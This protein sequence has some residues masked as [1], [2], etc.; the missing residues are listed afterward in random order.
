M[1]QMKLFHMNK[2]FF[3][4]F[5]VLTLQAHTQ[6]LTYQ[7]AVAMA[8][9]N[10]LSVKIFSNDTAIAHNNNTIGNAGMLPTLSFNAGGTFATNTTNQEYQTGLEINRSGVKSNN[11]NAGVLLNWTVFDGFRMFAAKD[12]LNELDIQS[13]YVLKTQ[14]EQVM[15]N[16]TASY[17]EVVRQKQQINTIKENIL[18]Y[19][20]RL[21]IAETRLEIGKSAKTD[22]LLAKVDLNDQKALLMQSETNLLNAQATLNQLLN[23]PVETSFDVEEEISMTYAPDYNTI[24]AG[25]TKKNNTYLAAQ[26]DYN[27]SQYMKREIAS[28]RYPRLNLSAAY[29]FTRNS[30]QAS[31]ILLNQNLGLNLGFTLSWTLFDGGRTHQQVKNANIAMMSN[32]LMVDETKLRI[33]LEL[34]A[35]WRTFET[36]KKV[37]ALQEENFALSKENQDLALERY[38]LGNITTVELKVVQQT[39]LD[40]QIKLLNARYDAKQAEIQLMKVNGDLV[41]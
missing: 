39:L 3:I 2:I 15:V 26:S 5:S 16:I 33:E 28:M 27:I 22:A 8:L 6:V 19:E 20:E 14:I 24:K 29:N 10:N 11:Y 12:R 40:I 35:A 7:Q 13:Q 38:K 36:T 23:Q 21:R 31:L 34:L 37:L 30:N 4:I 32:K 18:V 17:Y 25:F 1:F 41:K 9:Q